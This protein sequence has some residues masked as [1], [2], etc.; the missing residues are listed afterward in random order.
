MKGEK[1]GMLVLALILAIVVLLGFVLYLMV[2]RPAFTGY[3][4]NM[5]NQGVT[6]AVAS[7][8]QQAAT[9]SG[10]V[11]LTFEEQTI[12]VI[13]VECYPELFQQPA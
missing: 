5:Q 6:Y 9:C 8:M 12:N 11:P 3:A 2:V 1:K 7:I 4:V 10:P 13:A